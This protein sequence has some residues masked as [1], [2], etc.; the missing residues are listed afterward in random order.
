[1][2][3]F[4]AY[5][6][7]IRLF[8][9]DGGGD[10]RTVYQ[11]NLTMVG[12]PTIGGEMGPMISSKATVFNGSTQYGFSAESV[13]VGLPQSFL[14]FAKS[15]SDLAAQCPLGVAI[16][17]GGASDVSTGILIP[18]FR[19]N[20]GGDPLSAS[21][22]DSGGGFQTADTS[23]G[24]T[25]DEWHS[26]AFIYGAANQRRTLLD[27]GSIGTNSTSMTFTGDFDRY[28]VGSRPRVT[29]GD[30]FF[31]GSL[32]CLIASHAILSDDWAAY[33]AVMGN[34]ATFWNGWSDP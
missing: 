24:Y 3:R 6:D 25:V 20:T 30:N 28:V 17:A 32:S 11:N 8:L 16:T 22:I 13:P 19:G 23:S 9:P 14:G 21:A 4:N 12:S 34:Q 31:N 2:G 18:Q 29:P 15:Q 33:F 26:F 5:A 10:D 27:G 7:H 1:L